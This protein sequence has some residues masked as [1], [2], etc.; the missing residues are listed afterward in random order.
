MGTANL[1]ELML[2][3]HSTV[4]S[5][6]EYTT[7]T[8]SRVVRFGGTEQDPSHRSAMETT[9]MRNSVRQTIPPIAVQRRLTLDANDMNT[10]K[11]SCDI[12]AANLSELLLSDRS[13]LFSSRST[14]PSIFEVGS[15]EENDSDVE[16]NYSDV[17]CSTSCSSDE[18]GDSLSPKPVATRN[19]LAGPKRRT[20]W[21]KLRTL[22][23]TG[24]Q[25]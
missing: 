22:A 1:S 7:T 24:S 21:T 3:E 6:R 19:L 8:R 20:F 16:E 10:A 15:D 2:S 12:I 4:A 23:Y 13:S 25:S 9:E 5:F 17:F 14:V 18:N 11:S